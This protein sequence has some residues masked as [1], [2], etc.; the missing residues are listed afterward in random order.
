MNMPTDMK[1]RANPF[2]DCMEEILAANSIV[3][4]VAKV[5][6]AQGWSMSDKNV[7]V[8]RNLLPFLL[9]LWSSLQVKPPIMEPESKRMLSQIVRTH[10][11]GFTETHTLVAKVSHRS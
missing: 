2:S 9:Q 6:M 11:F 7:S 1:L 3:T 4:T 5:T 8:I 10:F